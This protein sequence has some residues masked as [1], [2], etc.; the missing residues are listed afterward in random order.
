VERRLILTSL[1]VGF[2][3]IAL[4]GAT[5]AAT[6]GGWA[7]LATAAAPSAVVTL[8]GR[9]SRTLPSGDFV[10]NDGT[11]LTTVVSA[12]TTRIVNLLGHIVPRQF[13]AA[14]DAAVVTGPQSG[15]TLVANL[16]EVR[17][18]LDFP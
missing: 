17:T 12:P 6:S 3:G 4:I 13:I 11:R 8:S 1:V 15:S 10:L 9:V 5:T 18:N 2:L 7:S 16:V 14:G